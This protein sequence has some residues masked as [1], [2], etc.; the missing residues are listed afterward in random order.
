MLIKEEL[1]V[2]G[3]K[4]PEEIILQQT[5]RNNPAN[6]PMGLWGVPNTGCGWGCE[7]PGLS[8]LGVPQETLAGSSVPSLPHEQLSRLGIVIN[9]W[10][11]VDQ[12]G[13]GMSLSWLS[14]PGKGRDRVKGNNSSSWQ[15]LLLIFLG[16][17]YLSEK[18]LQCRKE[19][20]PEIK[21]L[22]FPVGL[23]SLYMRKKKKKKNKP[24]ISK[25]T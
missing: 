6:P 19:I 10:K 23:S 16:L 2:K 13:G 15:G 8:M 20:F 7:S 3:R 21:L 12:I 11:K 18:L 25:G 5:A 14:L 9:A 4:T 24:K 17:E 22:L 1:Q